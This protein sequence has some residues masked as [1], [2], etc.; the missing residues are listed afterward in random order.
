MRRAPASG[1]QIAASGSSFQRRRYMLHRKKL[2]AIALAG[3]VL[4]PALAEAQN[5]TVVLYG[6][7]YPEM[8][9][10]QATGGRQ[11]GTSLS[12]LVN[13]PT[14]PSDTPNIISGER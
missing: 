9:W 2:L 12:T 6:R 7:L 13:G 11:P 4:A 5:A 14:G 1:G 8:I 3:T 10:A